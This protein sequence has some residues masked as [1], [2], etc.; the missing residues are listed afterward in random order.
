MRLEGNLFSLKP[1]N[2]FKIE[3]F[4]LIS[5]YVRKKYI[6]FYKTTSLIFFTQTRQLFRSAIACAALGVLGNTMTVIVLLATAH[7]RKHSTTPF[8]LSLALSDLIFCGFNLPLTA[9]RLHYRRQTSINVVKLTSLNISLAVHYRVI[10]KT[11]L[12]IVASWVKF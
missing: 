9:I 8:L 2:L 4:W 11:G 7:M 12:F 1:I 10:I 5:L 6:K 3:I